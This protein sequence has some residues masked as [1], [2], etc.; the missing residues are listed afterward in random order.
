MSKKI[1]AG[2][3]VVAGLAVAL[4]PAVTFATS[5]IHANASDSHTD[6]LVITVNPSCTFGDALASTPVDGVSHIA[7]SGTTWNESAPQTAETEAPAT[8]SNDDVDSTGFGIIAD[9]L[10]DSTSTITAAVNA[11]EH[12]AYRTMNAGTTNDAFAKTTL[13]V[14]CTNTDGYTVKFVTPALVKSAGVEIPAAA[15]YSVSASGYN[16]ATVTANNGTSGATDVVSGKA[17]A[18]YSASETALVKHT[19]LSATSGDTIDIVYGIGIQSNQEAGTY[20]GK[21]IYTLYQGLEDNA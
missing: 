5:T 13:K 7:V 20:A 21:V 18:A 8:H 11:S 2:L 19:G 14:V 1:I 12:T 16:L 10:P 3:G 17:T 15:T 9:E 6:E 4:T